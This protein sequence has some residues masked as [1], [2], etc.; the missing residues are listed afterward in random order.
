[1]A[2]CRRLRLVGRHRDR[3]RRS[4]STPPG[5][6]G[7]DRARRHAVSSSASREKSLNSSRSD[8]GPSPRQRGWD[9]ANDDHASRSSSPSSDDASTFGTSPV[10]GSVQCG[11]L[12]SP[13]VRDGIGRH[14]RRPLDVGRVG[15]A[16]QREADR[17]TRAVVGRALGAVAV[18]RRV[19]RQPAGDVFAFD[20]LRRLFGADDPHSFSRLVRAACRGETAPRPWTGPP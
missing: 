4:R 5:P 9:V 6:A 2:R 13:D 20:G 3:R 11:R 18:A 16:R 7:S 19:L 10:A 14:D 12:C 1:M 17:G 15:R 8:C